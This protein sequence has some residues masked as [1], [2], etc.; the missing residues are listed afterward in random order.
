[1]CGDVP[2]R[3]WFRPCLSACV[4][5]SE[6][7]HA[8]PTNSVYDSRSVLTSITFIP[9]AYEIATL[10]VDHEWA[11]G[12]GIKELRGGPPDKVCAQCDPPHRARHSTHVA[13][14]QQRAHF[15]FPRLLV[16]H[17]DTLNDAHHE[18]HHAA[19][20]S[21]LRAPPP[22]G[23]YLR[24]DVNGVLAQLSRS[25]AL[26]NASHYNAAMWSSMCSETSSA[27]G[28]APRRP[29][30]AVAH[31]AT[32]LYLAVLPEILPDVHCP[33]ALNPV[34]HPAP[35]DKP[36]QHYTWTAKSIVTYVCHVSGRRRKS[37]IFRTKRIVVAVKN[38][39]YNSPCCGQNYPSEGRRRCNQ[40]RKSVHGRRI[41][42]AAADRL[43][44]RHWGERRGLKAATHKKDKSY[45]IFVGR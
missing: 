39:G 17:P 18:L 26:H 12:S 8:C 43:P 9:F 4:N 24:P 14:G 35:H 42:T 29:K 32:C 22:A 5:V 21:L 3:A 6:S 16:V 23:R 7:D 37:T 2:K 30:R 19:C 13:T 27:T 36:R 41:A 34:P 40:N 25:D 44:Y 20:I 15:A 38:K 10:E 28:S 45:P 11:T 33:P 31:S 1:M